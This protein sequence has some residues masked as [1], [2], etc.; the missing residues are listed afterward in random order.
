MK[1]SLVN[2]VLVLFAITLVASAGVGG[3]YILTKEPIESAQEQKKLGAL[4]AVL[5]EFDNNPSAEVTFMELGGSEYAVYPAVKAG[6]KVG[7]AIE[8]TASGF[9]DAINIMTG[10][11]MDGKIVNIAVLKQSETPGLGAKLTNPENPVTQSIVGRKPA[12]IKMSVRKDGGDVDAITAST[13]SSRA[14]V[15][16]VNV[17]YAIFKT[18][19]DPDG[20]VDIESVTGATS[21]GNA[22]G[23]GHEAEGDTQIDAGSLHIGDTPED[24]AEVIDADTASGATVQAGES[25]KTENTGSNE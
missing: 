4:S 11:D 24:S 10:F 17:A 8:T 3:V 7:Y 1:S 18:I 15:N 13:I 6:N 21:L 19:V 5:P 22:A 14:Y 16:A 12:E 20:S 25:S 2:M 23:A 9:A